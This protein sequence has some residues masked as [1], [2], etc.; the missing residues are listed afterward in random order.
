MTRGRQQPLSTPCCFYQ[1]ERRSGSFARPGVRS[2]SPNSGPH[3]VCR[4]FILPEPASY[5][6]FYAFS[7]LRKLLYIIQQRDDAG[8]G[9]LPHELAHA[10]CPQK[11]ISGFQK[12]HLSFKKIRNAQVPTYPDLRIS[13]TRFD[14]ELLLISAIRRA[15]FLQPDLRRN[16]TRCRFIIADL[17]GDFKCFFNDA[18]AK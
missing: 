8:D 10:L 12:N 5:V 11:L 3:M 7:N 9:V 6:F 18:F 1:V 4:D 16:A 15:A 17:G 14:Y 13:A 2:H